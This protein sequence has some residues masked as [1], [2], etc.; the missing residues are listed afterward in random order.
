MDPGKYPFARGPAGTRHV[1]DNPHRPLYTRRYESPTGNGNGWVNGTVGH[2]GNHDNRRIVRNVV[3]SRVKVG[4]LAYV[5]GS[6][7]VGPL[8]DSKW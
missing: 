8:V 4:D 6:R 2:A 1:I 3:V 5:D 7:E